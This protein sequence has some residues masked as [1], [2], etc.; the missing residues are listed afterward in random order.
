MIAKRALGR[1]GLEVGALGLGCMGMSQSYG[2]GRR[3]RVDRDDPARHRAG[4]HLLRHR[5][6]LRA[7]RERGAARPGARR[8]ARP[9]SIIAT[10][11][12]FAIDGRRPDRGTRQPAGAHPRRRSEASL[13]RLGT[14]RI[15]LLYQHRVD[16]A[17]A[18]RGGG[19]RDGATSCARA[20]CASSA[21]PRPAQQTIRR[22][23]AVH[24]ISALQSEYSLWEREPRG[25]RSSRCCASWASGS[26]RSARSAAAS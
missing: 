12:G 25:A 15:D 9:A 20:R 11:F 19:R 8:R 16:P 10:K 3:C 1:Q 22:A 18:D 2:P 13:R 6:G 7:V 5:R 23:H 17:R 26:C 4:R 24:P 14:D 21:S